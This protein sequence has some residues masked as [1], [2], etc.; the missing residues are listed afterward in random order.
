MRKNRLSVLLGFLLPALCSC[1]GESQEVPSEFRSFIPRSARPVEYRVVTPFYENERI[2][3]PARLA[4]DAALEDVDMFEYLLGTSYS[5]LE[6]WEHAGVRFKPLLDSLRS[7]LEGRD[8]IPSDE[9]ERGLSAILKRIFDGHIALIGSGYNH[10][11]RHKAVYFCD[12]LVEKAGDGSLRVI[13]S[14][15]DAV[16]PGDLFT[17]RSAESF[18]FRTLS[19][20]GESHYLIGA[21]SFD[22]VT[23]ERLSF[24]NTTIGIPFH[25]SRMLYA[26]FDEAEP[27][28]AERVRGIP[29]IRAASFSDGVYPKMK[30]FM[31][32]GSEYKHDDTIVVNLLNN[33]GGS[34]AFPEGFIRNL[35]G[36]AEWELSYAVLTSPAIAQYYLRY[37]VSS[38]PEMSTELER[39]IASTAAKHE[40]YRASPAKTWEFGSAP[41]GKGSGTY[42]GTLI[43]LTNRRILSAG[44]AMVGY[45]Q[46]VKNRILIGENTGG[47]VQF[48][49]CQEYLLPHSRFV[50]KLP[51]RL[52][53]VPGFEECVG[54]LPDYWLDS[55]EPLAE[56]LRWAADPDGYRFEY[57][58]GF[59]EMLERN[60]FAPT[61]P[62]DARIEPPSSK[63]PEHLRAF[64]GK[65]FGAAEGILD[66]ILVVEKIHDNLEVDAIY[67]WGVA[68]QW[69]IERP[70]WARYRGKF[71]NG[72]LVL[73]DEAHGVRISYAFNASGSL[74]AVYERPGVRSFTTLTRVARAAAGEDAR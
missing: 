13:D 41:G 72:S 37:D 45:S 19:P 4:R 60:G 74:D 59:D 18:L 26:R 15:L 39:T 36:R 24:N 38:V 20:P 23:Q 17:E 27:F 54:Y 40:R 71:Q 52:L 16:K 50:V 70:G 5:G 32:A 48:S 21:L 28:S 58:C 64:S 31:N 2:E 29:V 56:V 67:A 11:Y 9:F 53:L 69:G 42:D 66:N 14:R 73:T 6:Y 62:A 47:V 22:P 63:V 3:R 1:S 57:A 34:S 55:M 12:V 30:E 61:L 8:S 46:S 25:K 65:W 49:D 7:A 51:R 44:E 68:F 43:I 35:N 33:G 10:A